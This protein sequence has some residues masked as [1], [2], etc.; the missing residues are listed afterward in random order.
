MTLTLFPMPVLTTPKPAPKREPHQNGRD[1][2]DVWLTPAPIIEALGPFALDPCAPKVQPWTTAARCFTEEDDGLAQDWDGRVWLNPPYSRPLYSRFMRRMAE[3]D[4]G[5][6]LVF[7]RTE[8]AD[9]FRY[10]WESATGALFLEGRLFF[11]RP[12]GE[13]AARCDTH[14]HVFVQYSADSKVMAC[15]YCGRSEA[16]AGAPSVLVA[17]GQDDA[18]VLAGSGLAGAFVPLRLPRSF[19]VVAVDVTWG[20]IV[21]ETLA[22]QGGRATVSDL[23]R[24]LS[25]HPKTRGRKHWQAK[26]RQTLQ[27]GGFRR[28]DRGLWAA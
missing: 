7:A 15:R 18:E 11:H 19:A 24:S 23:Y 13:D 2:S 12:D 25:R 14:D 26:V 3:H 20:E 27:R 16:N 22:R 17:Y 6:A 4:F 1:T 9:F 8:T 10:V 5:T 28:L 21:R